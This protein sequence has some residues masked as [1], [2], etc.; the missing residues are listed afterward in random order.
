MREEVGGLVIGGFELEPREWALDGVPWD[1][2]QK[3]FPPDWD[4]FAP[5]MEGAIRRVP[6]LEHADAQH[7]VHGPEALTPDS[8]PLLGPVPG[9]PG[10]WAACG[11]SHTGFGAGA[12]IGDIISQWIINGEPPYDVTELNVRRFGE[13]YRDRAY[14]SERA[15]EAYKYYYWLRFPHDENRARPRETQVPARR[16]TVGA[17]RRLW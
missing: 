12:A 10:Y 13:I 6:M 8:K 4:L 16:E 3:L 2:T 14:A 9:V 7:L 15:K 11:L 17:G 1:F 5:I